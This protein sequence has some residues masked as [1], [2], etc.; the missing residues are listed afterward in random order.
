MGQTTCAA[1]SG[2]RRP[3][4]WAAPRP[5]SQ[6]DRVGGTLEAGQTAA[7]LH[8]CRGSWTE[9]RRSRTYQPLGYNGLP[10]LKT[11]GIRFS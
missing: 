6:T 1:Q 7:N 5:V 2:R 9:R 10:V 4:P 3:P 8:F 11:V